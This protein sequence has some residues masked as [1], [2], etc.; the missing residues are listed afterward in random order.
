MRWRWLSAFVLAVGIVVLGVSAAPL[1][2]PLPPSVVLGDLII[3]PTTVMAGEGVTYSIQ[4][5]NVGATA[6]TYTLVFRYK[7]STGT[8]GS[9]TAEVALEPGQTKT[10][11]LRVTKSKPGTYFIAVDGKLGQ[12]TVTSPRALEPF[13][14]QTGIGVVT[15]AAATVNRKGGNQT[16]IVRTQ[17]G[18]F[19][20]YIVEGDGEFHH[21][22]RLA[23]RQPDGTWEVIAQGDAGT[24]PV[25]LEHATDANQHRRSAC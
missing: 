12:Y 8:V 20:A 25:S 21:E 22:W 24:F 19:T 17:D 5:S 4:V 2:P 3:A 11:M 23:R 15:R 10:V 14:R 18:V 7:T 16:R 1:P 13:A 6:G 9:D